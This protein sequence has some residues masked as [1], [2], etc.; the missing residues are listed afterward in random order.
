MSLIKSDLDGVRRLKE[1]EDELNDTFARI[2]AT[3]D[4]K[5]AIEYLKTI[6]IETWAG[7][8]TS[9]NALFY[10]EGMRRITAI[11]INRA[12]RGREKHVSS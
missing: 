11:M 3:P 4:G 9:G 10:L 5:R 6:S 12:K 8:E 2:A 1:Q 7:A